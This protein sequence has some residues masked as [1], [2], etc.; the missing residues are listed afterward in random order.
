VLYDPTDWR[1][2]AG[3]L[4]DAIDRY[5]LIGVSYDEVEK[6]LARYRAAAKEAK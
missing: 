3:E 6:L 4:A 5:R 1:A 2:L